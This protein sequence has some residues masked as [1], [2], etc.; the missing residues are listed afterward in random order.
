MAP[1]FPVCKP[2]EVIG[3]LEKKGFSKIS[4]KAVI[5][6]ILMA[7]RPLLFSIT[8]NLRLEH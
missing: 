3:I 2:K 5:S 4:Q 8:L 1:K 6:N 7:E